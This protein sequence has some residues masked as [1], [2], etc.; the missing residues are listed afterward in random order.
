MMGWSGDLPHYYQVVIS[1]SHD[2]ASCERDDVLREVL[3]DLAAI[4][5]A[6]RD[7]QVLRWR[8]LTQPDAVF[9]YRPGLDALRP[10]QRTL[11]ETLFLAGDYTATGWP[12]TMESA[13]RS[14]NLVAEAIAQS[15]AGRR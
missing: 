13:V 6:A 8:M 2:L 3:G 11:L 12:S 5:P 10:S 4:F 7:A 9:S 15:L 14:G 1:A